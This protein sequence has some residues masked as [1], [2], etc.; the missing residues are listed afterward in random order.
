MTENWS[1]KCHTDKNSAGKPITAN[2]TGKNNFSA[3]RPNISGVNVQLGD[4]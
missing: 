1:L 3:E 2:S 4:T